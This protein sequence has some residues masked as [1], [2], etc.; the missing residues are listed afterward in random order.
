MNK[1]VTNKQL[2]EDIVN[3]RLEID[4]YYKLKEG[5]RIL[6][7]LP[8]NNGLDC[9]IYLA[10]ITKFEKLENDC[11]VFLKQLLAL[12]KERGL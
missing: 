10:R 3:T 7:V 2:L 11:N 9:L 8:E 1:H 12:K 6:S 4:A 5:Y